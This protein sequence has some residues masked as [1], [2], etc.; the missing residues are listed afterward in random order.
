MLDISFSQLGERKSFSAVTE[1]F[2]VSGST[3]LNSAIDD[4]IYHSSERHRQIQGFYGVFPS[5][6]GGLSINYD[7]CN[8]KYFFNPD[9]AKTIKQVFP[10]KYVL[11][12]YILFITLP[13]PKLTGKFHSIN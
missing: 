5:A 11:L 1:K 4:K 12:I 6:D 7:K 3:P 9:L 13:A 10:L 2:N 8:K